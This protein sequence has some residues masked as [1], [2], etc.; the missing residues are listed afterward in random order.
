VDDGNP[1]FYSTYVHLKRGGLECVGDF[2]TAK[3]ARDYAEKL[4]QKYNWPITYIS[5]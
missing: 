3:A 1:L 2:N 5:R 4:S